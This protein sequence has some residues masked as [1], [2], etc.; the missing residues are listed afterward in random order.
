[1]GFL[2]LKFRAFTLSATTLAMAATL[3]SC[4]SPVRTEQPYKLT[5]QQF[6]SDVADVRDQFVGHK[7]NGLEVN[8]MSFD[9]DGH[10]KV[11]ARVYMTFTPKRANVTA[12]EI[13]DMASEMA[14]IIAKTTLTPYAEQFRNVHRTE[15]TVIVHSP[16]FDD[17]TASFTD[18]V[19]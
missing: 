11:A 13:D 15:A 6:Y 1:M 9:F 10:W 19:L 16:N 7:H 2:C 12:Q 18:E 17:I 3:T 8:S 4:A 14:A 5:Q